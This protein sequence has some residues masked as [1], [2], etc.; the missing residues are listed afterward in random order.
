MTRDDIA[1]STYEAGKKLNRLKTEFGLIDQKTSDSV[2]IRIEG[3]VRVMKEIDRL[4]ALPDVQEKERAL[5]SFLHGRDALQAYSMSTVCEKRELEW[6]TR[7][8]RMNFLKIMKT[9]LMRRKPN[10]P[11]PSST[12]SP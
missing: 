1:Y 6:P 2:D 10:V 12:G 7:F 11:V 3:A 8:I 5:E 4:M 9:L